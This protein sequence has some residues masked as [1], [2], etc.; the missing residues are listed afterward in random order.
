VP[1]RGSSRLEHSGLTIAFAGLFVLSGA[2]GLVYEVVWSRLLA[3]VFGVTAFAVSTVLVSFMGGMA[4]GAALLGRRADRASRPLRI[5]ALLEAGVG[6]FALVFPLVLSAVGA[7]QNRLFPILPDSF[8]LRSAIRFG[9]CLAILLPPTVLMGGTLPALG[10]GLIRRTEGLGRGVGLLYFVNTIGAAAGCWLAG[11]VLL[12]SIGLSRTTWVAAS[13]NAIVCLSA[14]ALDRR[15]PVGE[16]GPAPPAPRSLEPSRYA[17]EPSWWPLAVAWGSGLSAL[18]FEVV[19]FRVLV[20]VFGSTVYSF[21]AMLTV[22]LAGLAVGAAVAGILVDRLGNPVRLLSLAQ[23]AVAVSLLGGLLVVNEMPELFLRIL[24]TQGLSFEGM[25]RTKLLLSW[26]TLTLPALAFGAT[27]PVVVRLADARIGGTGSRIGRA[28][29]WNTAGAIVGAFVTG[30]VLLP[31]LGTERTLQ[32]VVAWSL[33]L[34]VGTLLSEPGSVRLRWAVPVGGSLVLSAAILVAAPP[35]DRRLLGAGVYVD[36]RLYL[37]ASGH[38]SVRNVVSDY[39]L[40]SYT[41]G[42]NDTITSY[43]SVIG[44][45]ITVNGSPTASDH[46]E[47]MFTQRMLGHLPMLFHPGPVRS[48][49]VVGLGAGV[50]TGA[51]ATHAP[52]RLT[53]VELEKGVFVAAGLFTKEN[54]GVLEDPALTVRL[55]DAKNFLRLTHERFDVITSHPNF[56]SLSG[57]GTLYSADFLALCRS[58]LAPG[59]VMLHW[60]PLSRMRPADVRTAVASFLAVF[61]HA[62]FYCVGLTLM[63]LGREEPFPPVDVGAL[64]ERAG[65]PRVAASLLD[66]GVRGPIE[67]M[68]YYEFDEGEARLLAGDAVPS[69]DDRPRVEFDAPRGLFEA[70]VD[71]NLR[72]IE[73]VRPTREERARRLGL[74]GDA[75]GSYLALAAA[76]DDARHAEAL[77]G[78]GN[79]DEAYRI[80]I[81]VADSGQRYGRYLVSEH[82]V[83]EGIFAESGGRIADANERFA[84]ALRYDPDRLDALVGAGY[85]DFFLGRPAEAE[86]LLT[87]AATLYPRSA[88]ALYRLAALRESQ[89][90][91]AEAESLLARAIAL[92]PDLATPHALLGSL[93]LAAKRP[94]DALE[95]LDTAIRLG[96]RSEGA[97]S[98]RAEA[99]LALGRTREAFDAAKDAALLYPRSRSTLELLAS[100][101]DALGN[102]REAADTRIRIRD[103]DPH[104]APA[105]A[106]KT[107]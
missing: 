107:R 87:R 106:G 23:A 81:P 5:F 52:E 55:D 91:W 58:R 69:T 97:V 19:W 15:V 71:S 20:L 6:L 101:A 9:L 59:G 40:T 46:F 21:S 60:S 34:A 79:T 2:A 77:F 51:I 42:Y 84:L 29:A 13:V 1:G 57:S 48:V 36:P 41:E 32:L 105:G 43:E 28:Y 95:A 3:Q 94:E 31:R 25:S 17:T 56:P 38:A 76:Y 100:C 88:G 35:W 104:D 75:R 98:G 7:I 62:R 78:E 61:P 27:F 82:A 67:S 80:L 4:L 8:A 74:E 85:T 10:A 16:P 14:L 47:D 39:R 22:F 65:A 103:L 83:A 37:D 44:K 12:P 70:T 54:Q 72:A 24:A 89:S 11:F 86:L 102:R 99:L 50:T 93:R 30:F 64:S 53:A 18:A 33:V 63:M 96:D 66:V 26:L 73:S 92:R 45:F 49:C 68:A 90:R